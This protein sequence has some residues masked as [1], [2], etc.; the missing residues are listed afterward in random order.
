MRLIIVFKSK[1]TGNPID[2][3]I[4][5]GDRFHL[6]GS[7]T[8]APCLTDGKEMRIDASRILGYRVQS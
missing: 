2:V 3:P 8:L 6:D 5:S 7:V 1:H 4:M